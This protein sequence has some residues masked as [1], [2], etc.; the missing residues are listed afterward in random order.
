MPKIE[1]RSQTPR[2]RPNPPKQADRPTAKQGK[3][4]TGNKGGVE[5]RSLQ[6]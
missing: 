5:K 4:N 6:T 3:S 2:K 1:T